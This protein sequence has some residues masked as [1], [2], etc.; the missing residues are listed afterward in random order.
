MSKRNGGKKRLRS[1]KQTDTQAEK[2]SERMQAHWVRNML[3]PRRR[4]QR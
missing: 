2:M 3:E 4:K 1:K